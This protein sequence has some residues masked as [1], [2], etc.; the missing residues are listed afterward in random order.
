MRKFIISTLAAIILPAISYGADTIHEGYWEMVTTMK[1][2]GMPIA[3]PPTKTKHCFSKDDVKDQKK[4]ITTDKN[5]TVTEFK[6]SGNKMTW[7]MKCTGQNAGEFSGETVFKGDAYDSTM[8]MEAQGQTM[9]LKT[10]AKR[11]GNCP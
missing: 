8:N 9:N 10:K 2:P 7:K 6:K 4:T 1:M 5:C 3:M 11:L